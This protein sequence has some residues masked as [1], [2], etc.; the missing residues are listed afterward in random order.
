MQKVCVGAHPDCQRMS[1][2]GTRMHAC[3]SQCQVAGP[4][5][6]IPG[7]LSSCT[8]QFHI[9]LAASGTTTMHTHCADRS[10][11]LVSRC[12]VEISNLQ[13]TH[14]LLLTVHGC[15]RCF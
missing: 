10:C 7:Y 8:N 2:F 14:S 11:V 6:A 4:A 13:F 9:S 12:I 1:V 5:L 3:L 15:C